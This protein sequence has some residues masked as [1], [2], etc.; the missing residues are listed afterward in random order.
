MSRPKS[1]KENITISF[2]KAVADKLEYLC[3]RNN[4]NK[5]NV[6]NAIVRRTIM[7]DAEFYRTLAKDYNLKMQ[8]AL[9]M[10]EQAE[11]QEQLKTEINVTI[12]K[13]I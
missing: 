3:R 5:S 8:E 9:F 11:T 6:V 7:S 10:K 1:G 12:N 2:D 13:N 4:T